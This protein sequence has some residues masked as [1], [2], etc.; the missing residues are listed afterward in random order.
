[1]IKELVKLLVGTAIAF[2]GLFVIL[3]VLGVVR[4]FLL[5][6]PFCFGLFTAFVIR[7]IFKEIEEN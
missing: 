6:N 1:M 3:V 5:D 4:N 2:G 7:L